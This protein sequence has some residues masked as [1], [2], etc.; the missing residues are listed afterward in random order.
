MKRVLTTLLITAPLVS[1]G[2]AATSQA[3]PAG[4]PPVPDRAGTQMILVN[5][6][7]YPA[8]PTSDFDP[9]VRHLQP[10][11]QSETVEHRPVPILIRPF[12][13]Q[14][15]G[16][17]SEAVGMR[18]QNVIPPGDVNSVSNGVPEQ[19][20]SMGVYFNDPKG[21]QGI[22]MQ[23]PFPPPV[24]G[25]T[26]VPSND[27]VYASDSPEG[28]PISCVEFGI[29]FNGTL[30]SFYAY[31]Q[32]ANGNY[33]QY[34]WLT[35]T[36]ANE[37]QPITQAE[38]NTYGYNGS[39]LVYERKNGNGLSLFIWNQQLGSWDDALGYAVTGSQAS[40]LGL[41]TAT[42]YYL[43]AGSC[44]TQQLSTGGSYAAQL[45][46]VWNGSTWVNPPNAKAGTVASPSPSCEVWNS[47]AFVPPFYELKPLYLG[48]NVNGY[49]LYTVDTVLY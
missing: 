7:S 26:Y 23:I 37:N 22:Y 17:G 30:E 6:V 11:P 12:G 34:N 36:I 13:F 40:S 32:C 19:H 8:P 44:P 1:S 31:D 3:V 29:R 35:G 20:T 24:S 18:P 21:F 14:L 45:L 4:I 38:Y 9:R 10:S 41:W 46:L 28:D 25:Y 33:P 48:S 2:C 49:E 39:A 43:Q 15:P 5:G 27:T 47:F 16:R 42:E